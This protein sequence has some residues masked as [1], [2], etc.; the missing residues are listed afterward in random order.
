MI[1]LIDGNNSTYY[2]T[3]IPDATFNFFTIF[4]WEHI[5]PDY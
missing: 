2:M 5:F 4:S 1:K 3:F